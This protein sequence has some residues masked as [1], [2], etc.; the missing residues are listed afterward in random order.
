MSTDNFESFALKN[1]VPAWAGFIS[2]IDNGATFVHFSRTQ[3]ALVAHALTIVALS[4]GRVQAWWEGV[5]RREWETWSL[6]S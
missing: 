4:R 3:P 1:S 2:P 6:V 5:E